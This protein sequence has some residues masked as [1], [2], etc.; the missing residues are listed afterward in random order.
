MN[1]LPHQM[2]ELIAAL[3]CYC[4]A[5]AAIAVGVKSLK[6][7]KK[8][9]RKGSKNVIVVVAEGQAL[10]DGEGTIYV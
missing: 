3:L 1:I 5:V 10:L 6:Q 2:E 4:L 8:S 9:K 7:R